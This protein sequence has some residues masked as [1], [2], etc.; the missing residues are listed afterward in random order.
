MVERDR[1]VVEGTEAH[2]V[3][4]PEFCERELRLVA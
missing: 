1:C 3:L 2:M 4:S